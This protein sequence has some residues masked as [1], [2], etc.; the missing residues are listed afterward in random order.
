[1]LGGVNPV[2]YDNVRLLAVSS[3]APAGPQIGSVSIQGTNLVFQVSGGASAAGMGYS[4][5]TGTNVTEALA[6]WTVLTSGTFDGSGS[7]PPL[8]NAI[9][10]GTPQRFFRIRIP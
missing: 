7:T 8:T 10:P 1:V 2:N 9:I 5:V 3:A 6:N 4:I